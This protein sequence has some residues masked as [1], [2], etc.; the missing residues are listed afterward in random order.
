MSRS[1]RLSLWQAADLDPHII[2][3]TRDR[4]IRPRPTQP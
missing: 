2:I 1:A 4:T 3:A